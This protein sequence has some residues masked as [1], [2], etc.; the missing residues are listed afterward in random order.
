[1]LQS[2][3]ILQIED[4]LMEANF[5]RTVAEPEVIFNLS[6]SWLFPNL[7]APCLIDK[8]MSFPGRRVSFS[9]I[10]NYSMVVYVSG[11]QVNWVVA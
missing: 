11:G 7:F 3:Y 5:K 6:M 1:M 10:P 9:V 4:S 2:L 8:N